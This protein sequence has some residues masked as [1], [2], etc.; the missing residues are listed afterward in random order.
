MA[1]HVQGVPEKPA[2]VVA[3]PS[4]VRFWVGIMALVGVSE[5]AV[6]IAGRKVASILRGVRGDR[7]AVTGQGE[8]FGV[9]QPGPHGR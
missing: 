3:V 8:V 9:N 1:E 7:R 5:R 2:I 4:P 6:G